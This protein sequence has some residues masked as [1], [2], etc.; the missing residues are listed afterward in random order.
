M[1]TSSWFRA[2]LILLKVVGIAKGMT[3]RKSSKSTENS[4]LSLWKLTMKYVIKDSFYMLLF[5]LASYDKIT[6][7]LLEYIFCLVLHAFWLV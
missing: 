5:R 1:T 7:M 4:E 3:L 6:F 2:C